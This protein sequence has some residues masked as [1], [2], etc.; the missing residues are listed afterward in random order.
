MVGQ[1]L[2][3]CFLEWRCVPM[4]TAPIF[5]G[6]TNPNCGVLQGHVITVVK[7]TMRSESLF[8]KVCVSASA[9]AQLSSWQSPWEELPAGLSSVRSRPLSSSH[10]LF[11]SL[12]QSVTSALFS[13][14]E[15]AALCV[16]QDF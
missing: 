6:Q 14:R 9:K 8:P 13:R 16:I 7:H 11:V 1:A 3:T 10:F 12:L 2:S 15:S 4:R 5:A